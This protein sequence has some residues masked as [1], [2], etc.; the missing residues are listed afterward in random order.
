MGLVNLRGFDGRLSFAAPPRLRSEPLAKKDI[1][2]I[3]KA[4]SIPPDNWV[5]H[6]W[7]DNGAP[8]MM[9][10]LA[11]PETVRA[12]KV[13]RS[14]LLASDYVGL[15]GVGDEDSGYAC[16][17]RALFSEGED[18]VTGSLNAAAAQWMR[19]RSV[20]PSQYHVSQG[21]QVGRNGQVFVRD[22]GENI[23]IGGRVRVVIAGTVT[24]P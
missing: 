15:I 7:G 24:L 3:A 10:Q 8:W 14:K 9:V 11:N 4:I 6:A 17:V 19:E 12:V 13:D 22:D 23:W 2:R 21:S 20:V 1:A 18:P 5:G 16:E